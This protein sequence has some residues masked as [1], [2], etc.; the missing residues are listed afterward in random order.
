MANTGEKIAALMKLK[1]KAAPDITHSLADL[2]DGSMEKGLERIAMF[3]TDE[4]AAVKAT[5]L[6]DG[7]KKGIAQGALTVL[8][9]VAAVAGIQVH[10]K[11]KQEQKAK[12]KAHEAEGQAILSVMESAI[13]DT[14]AENDEADK[15]KMS[16]ERPKEE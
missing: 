8:I 1:G 11:H 3:F 5:A 13:T 12:L 2:G 4:I 14:E 15:D 16:E 6:A 7:Q 9:V 10:T